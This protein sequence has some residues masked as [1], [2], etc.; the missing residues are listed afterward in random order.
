MDAGVIAKPEG[1]N[2]KLETRNPKESGKPEIRTNGK[3]L[4]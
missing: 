3:A 2:P 4:V 1:G